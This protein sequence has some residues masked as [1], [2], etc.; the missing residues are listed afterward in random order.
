MAVHQHGTGGRLYHPV[1]H[2]ERGGFAAA[3]GTHEDGDR[4]PFNVQCQVM[5][6]RLSG[7]GLGDSRNST[8]GLCPAVAT[9]AH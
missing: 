8:I 6:G 9:A 1:N 4:A 2:P 7:I 5:D 3:R